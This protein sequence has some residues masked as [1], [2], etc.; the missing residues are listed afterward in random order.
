MKATRETSRTSV[1]VGLLAL[2]LI[3]FTF[4]LTGFAQTPAVGISLSSAPSPQLP[5]SFTLT[6]SMTTARKGHTATLLLDGRVLVVG[7]NSG[8]VAS[9]ELYD[10]RSGTF[11]ATGSLSRAL[12][13]HRATLLQDGRTLITG[14]GGHAELYNPVTGTFTVTGSMIAARQNHTATLLLSGKVLITGSSGIAELYD[15]QTGTFTATG[16]TPDRVPE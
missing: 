8:G 9:A 13:N 3:L 4:T 15:S 5:G 14:E 10:P 12:G 7:G 16:I 6:G 11:S 2:G 1:V